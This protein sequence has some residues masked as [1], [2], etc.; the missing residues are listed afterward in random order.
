MD[1]LVV[2]GEVTPY[3]TAAV[4]AYGTA[5]LTRSTD[6]AADA[7]VSLGRR[8]VQRLWNRD[9]SRE[10]IEGAVADLART[11][12]DEDFQALLRAHI[13]RA[14]LDDPELAAEIARMLPAAGTSFTASGA[15]AVAVQ[16]NSGIISTGSDTTIQR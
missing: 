10:A 2:A 3:I 16:N 7:T 13:K 6:T 4:G 8:I 14:L 1:A 12:D 5:V 9:E 15:G 11:P